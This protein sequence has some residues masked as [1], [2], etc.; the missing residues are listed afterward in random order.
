MA[1]PG[2]SFTPTPLGHEDNLEFR[3]PSRR[4][5]RTFRLKL[6]NDAKSI[7]KASD[8]SNLSPRG[9]RKKSDR[10]NLLSDCSNPSGIQQFQ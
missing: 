5:I 4:R 8:D 1:P 10:Q 3:A 2:S 7:R 6:I 9:N